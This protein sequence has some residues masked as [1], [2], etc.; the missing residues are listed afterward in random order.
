MTREEGKAE[1]VKI[2]E[3][4]LRKIDGINYQVFTEKRGL[5][6][7]DHLYFD[8]EK[9]LRKFEYDEDLLK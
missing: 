3:E 8:T 9:L 4:A 5:T 1:I 2:V 6:A 7:V